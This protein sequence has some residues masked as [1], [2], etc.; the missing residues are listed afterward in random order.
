MDVR[1]N[2]LYLLKDGITLQT[3]HIGVLL[4]N[5]KSRY[6]SSVSSGVSIMYLAVYRG[7]CEH[8]RGESNTSLKY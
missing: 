5:Y 7:I 4:W 2:I 6:I 1:L 8:A 3:F